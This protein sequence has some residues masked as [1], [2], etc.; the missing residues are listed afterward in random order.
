MIPGKGPTHPATHVFQFRKEK[1]RKEKTT[2]FGAELMRRL[3]TYPGLDKIA[4]TKLQD[5]VRS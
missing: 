2:A 5:M 3:V 4:L 1:D